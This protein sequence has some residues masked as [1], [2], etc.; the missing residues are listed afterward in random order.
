[1]PEAIA[2]IPARSGSKRVKNKNILKIKGHPLLA[3]TISAAL[4]SKIFNK[5]ICVTDSKKYAKI[6]KYYGAEV[7]LLRPKKYSGD[8]SSDIEW[9]MWIMKKINGI[10]KYNIFSILRPTN[11]LRKPITIK[12]A[13]NLF[14]KNKKFDSLRAVNQCKQHPAKM[15]YLKKKQL[16]PVIKNNFKNKVP[17]HSQQYANL[18]EIYSQNASLEIAWSK[19]LK[20]KNPTISGD[21]IL[22]FVSK[23]YEGFDINNE[24]DIYLLKYLLRKKIAKIQL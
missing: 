22:G 18:P 24:E 23:S 16:L 6:A 7:P 17:L 5:V 8:K 10:E 12:R 11:P 2:L 3:Y 4:K 13:Y 21:K 1:M 20:R 9:V 15:W 14:I 19:I